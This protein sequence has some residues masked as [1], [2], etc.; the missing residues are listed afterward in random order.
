M[1]RPEYSWKNDSFKI[2]DKNDLVIYELL[3]RDFSE[4]RDLAG[5]RAQ[6]DSLQ[7]LGINAIELLP[8]QELDGNLS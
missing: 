3:L 6:L 5:A 2:E 4:T 1:D 7:Q 8:V